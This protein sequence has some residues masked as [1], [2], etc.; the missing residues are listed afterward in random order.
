MRN[1]GL[2]EYFQIN[3]IYEQRAYSISWDKVNIAIHKKVAPSQLLYALNGTIVGLA[4]DTRSY[5][6]TTP[7]N[8]VTL[9]N[10]LPNIPI[11]TC[12]GLGIIRNID[13][14]NREFIIITPLPFEE[15]QKV[16]TILR[17]S[18]EIPFQLLLTGPISKTPYLVSDTLTIANEGSGSSTKRQTR[19]IARRRLQEQNN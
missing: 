6:N 11:C 5:R 15:L 12:V 19:K 16:N 1:E 17:G 2:R 8:E 18:Q 4:I 9:F 10:L 13:I 7:I 3:S 14:T